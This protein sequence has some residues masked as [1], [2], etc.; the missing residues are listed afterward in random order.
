MRKC[1]QRG[2]YIEYEYDHADRCQYTDGD[3]AAKDRYEAGTDNARSSAPHYERSAVAGTRWPGHAQ[4]GGKNLD[5]ATSE[6]DSKGIQ[7][8]TNS[9]GEHVILKFDWGVCSTSPAAGQP[10]TGVVV[11]NLGHFSCGA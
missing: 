7:S 4:R 10:V 2:R 3:P 8:A 9:N 1:E 5:D 11:L 6:L